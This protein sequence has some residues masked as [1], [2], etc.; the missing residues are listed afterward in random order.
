MFRSDTSRVNQEGIKQP[1]ASQ[2]HFGAFNPRWP[3]KYAEAS[4]QFGH[5]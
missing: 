2:V 5:T 1:H 3:E 4:L